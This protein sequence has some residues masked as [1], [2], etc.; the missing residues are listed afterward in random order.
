[1]SKSPVSSSGSRSAA[2]WLID[3]SRF[4]DADLAFFLRQLGSSEADRYRAFA[5]PERRRQFLIGRM[6]LRFAVGHLLGLPCKSLSVEERPTDAPRLVLPSSF[7]IPPGFSLSHSGKWVACAVSRDA[8]LGLDIELLEPDRDFLEIGRSAF[9]S[10]EIAWIE[11]LPAAARV[12][13]FYQMWSL[14]EAL[15]KLFSNANRGTRFPEPLV[16][17]KTI[18]AQGNGWHSCMLSH[19]DLSCV[20]CSADVSVL[21]HLRHP[22][23]IPASMLLA[24]IHCS[25]APAGYAAANQRSIN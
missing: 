12:A 15:F 13:A 8:S 24:A 22:D 5:R 1:L 16:S 10:D 11:G 21:P 9:H 3:G 19:A 18:A 20:L 14:H 17:G 25:R 7:E 2:V 4:S 23:E 6:M